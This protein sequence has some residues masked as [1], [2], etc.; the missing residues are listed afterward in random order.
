GAPPPPPPPP[1]PP[2]PRARYVAFFASESHQITPE[3]RLPRKARNARPQGLLTWAMVE[4]LSRKPAT[5]RDL[6]DGVL[7]LYPS[8]IDE[9]AQRFPTRELPSPVAEGNLDAPLFA[10]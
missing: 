4:A 3:L 9:L 7:A 5:W 6:F 2:V 1:P 10:N 8:V